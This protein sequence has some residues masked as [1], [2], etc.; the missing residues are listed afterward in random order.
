M[1]VIINGVNSDT[2]QGLQILS[3]P[4]ITKPKMRTSV[5]TID[6]RPGDIVTYLGYEAYNKTIKIL[7]HDTYDLPAIMAYFNQSGTIIFSNDPD[8]IY[9]FE[10][11]DQINYERAVKFKTASV[12]IHVQPYKLSA[13]EEPATGEVSTLVDKTPYIIRRTPFGTRQNGSI[14]GGSV[15]WNQLCNSASVTI[16]NGRKYFM[17]K[18]TD[19]SIGASTGTAITGLT[20]GSDMVIDLTLMFGAEIADYIYTQEQATAGAGVAWCKAY[21]PKMFST[22][23]PYNAGEIISVNASAHKMVGFN[24]WDEEWRNGYYNSATGAFASSNNFVA[25]ANPIPVLPNTQYYAEGANFAL[26]AYDANKEFIGVITRANDNTFTTM[27]NCAF[28]N[29]NRGSAYG[30]KY[31]N[32]ICI[33]ISDPSRNGQYESYNAHTYPL[34]S[35]LTLRGLPKLDGDNLYYDGD[36]YKADGTVERRYAVR[37]YQSGDESDANVLTDGTNTVYKLATPTTEQAEPYKA[38]QI[39]D[40]NGTEEWVGANM[41]V[42]HETT[43][44]DPISMTVTNEGN[45][46]S[47]PSITIEGEGTVEVTVDGLNILQIQMP[48]SGE[49][50][51]DSKTLDATDGEGG[52]ANRSVTGDYNDLRLAPGEHTV[53]VT[54]DVTSVTIK[55]ASRWI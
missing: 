45:T 49:I 43:Y 20:S 23:Q 41:P 36:I 10:T 55:N 6:G 39:C 4:P 8:K 17:K 34:D 3:L 27:P 33:N 11:I 14:V 5:A 48:V 16:P 7:L 1:Y 15:V 50:T 21:N 19:Y 26:Y 44:I 35:S 9:T 25:N 31:K 54:G 52:L 30:K 53:T 32:D 40:P 28:I 46:E 42:G 37:A 18:G 47:A 12:T 51:I 24:Q 29:F 13:T 22:Y 2:I 38:L